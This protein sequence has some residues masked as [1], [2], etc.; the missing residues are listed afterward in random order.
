MA[1]PEPHSQLSALDA[2]PAT[3]FN[4]AALL[5]LLQREAVVGLSVALTVLGTCL[6]A[7]VLVFGALGPDYVRLGAAA[8]V[9]GAIFGGA[10]AAAAARSSFI[11]WTPQTTIGLVQ[12]SLAASLIG[13]PYFAANHSAAEIAMVLCVA[14]TGLL[15]ILFGLAGLA[16]IIKYMPH[17]VLAGFM[18]GVSV[19]ILLSQVKQFVSVEGLVAGGASLITR[20]T[21]FAFVLALVAFI[22]W[23]ETQTKKISAPLAGL[24]VGLSFYHAARYLFPEFDLGPTLGRLPVAFPP[25]LPLSGI[26]APT[27]VTALLDALPSIVTIAAAMVVVGTFQSLLAF[28]MAE[29]FV[30]TPIPAGRGLIALGLGDLASAA[31]GGLAISV[32]VPQTA[33]SFRGGGRTRLV[34]LTVSLSLLLLAV[35]LPDL[36]GA[37]PLA[38]IIALLIVVAISVF[39]RWS[40]QQIRALLHASSAAER[41]RICY[42][43]AVVLVVMG[44]IIATSVVPGILAGFVA[45]CLTFVMRMSQPIVRRRLSGINTHSQRVRT[46]EDNA[47]LRDSGERRRILSLNGVLFFGNAET[48]S[49]E[50]LKTF[51]NADTV[52]LDCRN[53]T[54]IDASGANIIRELV[55]KS[56]K[57]GKLLWFSNVPML[58]RKTIERAVGDVKT[59]SVFSDLESALEAAEN[60][61][62]A[63]QQR[64]SKLELVQVPDHDLVRGLDDVDLA[65]FTGLLTKRAYSKGTILAAEG[66]PGDR[67]WVIMKGSVDIRLR[68]SDERGTRRIASLGAGTTVGEMALI[69]NTTRSANIIAAEDIECWELNRDAY[70]RMMRD[71]P[72]IGAKLLTNLFR[73]AARRIRR[74]SEQ[75]REAES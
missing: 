12:A 45:A 44:V 38:V 36:L 75:L 42:D 19:S 50:V 58:Y 70:D 74:T 67:M 21:M 2:S 13:I 27:T 59:S 29:N 56:R 37:I 71:H 39:D 48:L 73:E 24:I 8:G 10:C 14:L 25:S 26:L 49:R 51:A 57:L 32:A 41:W 72:Q 18:N 47:R 33:A 7:G 15:Q 40:V 63:A 3:R 1:E 4:A 60:S 23:F 69:E 68:V 34:G 35:L 5:N 31:V 61:V 62:L 53:V 20:P 52:I 28:R 43:L 22:F 64:A 11:L 17:P 9:Y 55:E 54:D 6:A 66:D 46:A 30:G 16:K 65:A